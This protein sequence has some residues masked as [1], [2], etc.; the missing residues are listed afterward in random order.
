[1]E[2]SWSTWRKDSSKRE[3][4]GRV[5]DCKTAIRGSFSTRTSFGALT[6]VRPPTEK[7]LRF[8]AYKHGVN[9]AEAKELVAQGKIKRWQIR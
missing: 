9:I 5:D 3:P 4:I 6:S 8:I 1:M 7:E 2:E